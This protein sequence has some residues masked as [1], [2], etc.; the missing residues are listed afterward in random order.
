MFILQ[1]LEKIQLLH[2]GTAQKEGVYVLQSCGFDSVPADMGTVYI[3]RAFG[4]DHDVNDVESYLR[5]K[6]GPEVR[7]RG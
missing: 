2:H 6:N 7:N 4:E 3:Q 1:F 5:I